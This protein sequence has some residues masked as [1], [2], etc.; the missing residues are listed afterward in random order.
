MTGVTLITVFS[1]IRN[2]YEE[3]LRITPYSV[4]MQGNTNQKN[5]EYRYFSRS[6]FLWQKFFCQPKGTVWWAQNLRNIWLK[7]YAE[8]ILSDENFV[9]SR[10]RKNW[11]IIVYKKVNL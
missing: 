1:L 7:F 6:D 9:L 3:I 2:K 5:P 4:W 8:N 10:V 11:S